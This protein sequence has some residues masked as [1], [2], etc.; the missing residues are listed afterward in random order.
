VEGGYVLNSPNIKARVTGYYSTFDDGMNVMTFYHDDVRNFVN[1]A[2]SNI[3]KVHYGGE[4]GVE[5]KVSGGVSVNAAAAIGR[6]YFNSRQNALVTVDNN[7]SQLDVT[8]ASQTIYSQNFRVPS[9]P[10]EAYS[11]GLTYRSPNFWFV[12]LT[13]SYSDQMYLDFNPIRRTRSAI[14]GLDMTKETD[15]AL[16]HSIIDQ[17]KLDPQFTL[18]FFG[19]YSWKVPRK[20]N[21]GKNTFI[22]FNA[23]VNNLLNNKDIISGGFEQLRFDFDARNVNK[24]PAKLYYA[25]G[26]NYFLSV[27]FRFQK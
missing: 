17:Q 3:D 4:F 24:Y 27:T 20:Y 13:G 14:D 1:Y 9:T 22:V 12:S 6:Y 25:Y 5:A 26:L 8:Q 7:S 15:V 16:Y 19:G 2:I 18:D 21:L 11:L 23:G 10:Q